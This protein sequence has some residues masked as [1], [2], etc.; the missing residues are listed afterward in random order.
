M[1]KQYLPIVVRRD[2]SSVYAK[3]LSS[4][5]K[6]FGDKYCWTLEEAQY[7]IEEV[8]AKSNNTKPHTMTCGGFGI[9][10]EHYEPHEVIN[11]YIKVRTVSEWEIV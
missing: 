4:K 8:T 3:L 10:S 2:G 1:K 6:S 5:S 7:I 9:T 11:S